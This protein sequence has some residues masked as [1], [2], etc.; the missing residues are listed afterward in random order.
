MGLFTASFRPALPAR[1]PRVPATEDWVAGSRMRE[2]PDRIGERSADGPAIRV[3]PATDRAPGAPS[4]RERAPGSVEDRPLWITAPEP[5]GERLDALP[6]ERGR[7]REG[8]CELATA[9]ACF[10]LTEPAIMA[11]CFLLVEPEG[12]TDGPIGALE[13]DAWLELFATC[14]PVVSWAGA[15]ASDCAIWTGRDGGTAPE[16]PADPTRIELPVPIAAL[17]P[18]APAAGAPIEAPDLLA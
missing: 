1:P 16:P 5:A 6:A 18:L 2:A 8:V 17:E 15:S 11:T 4:T 10:A 13:E 9:G 7:A 3:G 14:F 12:V